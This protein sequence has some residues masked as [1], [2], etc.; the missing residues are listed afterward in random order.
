[1]LRPGLCFE[2]IFENVFVAEDDRIGTEC[3][4][5]ASNLTC[6]GLGRAKTVTGLSDA[7]PL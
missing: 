3:F 5:Q 7:W 1:M 6:D 4:K 2:N